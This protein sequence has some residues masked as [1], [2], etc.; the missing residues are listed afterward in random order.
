MIKKIAL[1]AALAIATALPMATVA[2]AG[3]HYKNKLCK[4]T[5]LQGKPVTFTCKKSQKC[6]FNK[7]TNKGTCP[8]KKGLLGGKNLLCL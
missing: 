4:A 8:S 5:S 2:D 3:G 6:C 7:L 1:T